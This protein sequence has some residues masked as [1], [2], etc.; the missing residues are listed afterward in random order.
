MGLYVNDAREKMLWF[1]LCESDNGDALKTVAPK[2]TFM[3]RGQSAR[4]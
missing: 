3:D 1:E 4:E 2:S